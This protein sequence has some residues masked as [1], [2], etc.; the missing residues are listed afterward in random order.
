MVGNSD[1]NAEMYIEAIS[2]RFN[3][4]NI[5]VFIENGQKIAER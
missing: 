5:N 2:W 3:L 1:Q 4:E